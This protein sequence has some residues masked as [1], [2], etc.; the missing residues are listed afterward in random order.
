MNR[1]PLNGRRL[2]GAIAALTLLAT[3]A[4]GCEDRDE[5]WDARVDR[6]PSAWGLNNAVAIVDAHAERVLLLPVQGDLEFAPSS[7]P[8]GTGFTAAAVTPD[9]S[10]MLVL[11]RGDVPR[12]TA[13]D[14]PP[15][16][17][18]LAGW[19][20]PG[21]WAT[22]ELSDPLSAL[23]LDPQSEYAVIS[24]SADDV[25]F[26]L[27]PNE[28][29]IV[30]LSQGPTAT[31]PFPLTIRSFGGRP[32]GFTFTPTLNVPGGARRLLVVQTDRDVAL[33]DFSNLDAPEITVPLTGGNELLV[34]G[35]VAVSDGSAESD[36][37]SRVAIRVQNDPSVII[38]DLLSV[39]PE[40]AST[41]PQTFRAMPNK[42]HVGGVP[43]DISFVQTDG[44]LRLAALVPSLGQ[45]TLVD[46]L[47]GITSE[48][49][50]GA[51]FEHLS[52]VTSIVGQTDQGSD[53]A[54][55]WSSSSK[56]I[57]FWA[58]GSTVGQ[59]YKSVDRL[60]LAHTVAQVQDVPAPNNHLKVLLAPGETQFTVLDLV[61]RTA[62]PMTSSQVGTQVT[63]APDGGRAWI[64]AGTDSL[65]QLNLLSLHP[66]NV[67]LSLPVTGVFDV[68]RLDGGRAVVAVH[69]WGGI[70]ATVLD[71]YDPSLTTANQYIGLLLGELP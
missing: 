53:V 27:N 64:W 35:G 45:L 1:Y 65:A 42:V 32:Q 60:Q 19:G 59:P 21:L 18:V 36:E 68:A 34:P 16:L 40:Q 23:A 48:V 22:Y 66:R 62:S 20:Q 55:L 10:R 52:L 24:P 30:D 43:S 41:T 25:T 14:E 2:V 47:T 5:A 9:H 67:I 17:H 13:D 63:I 50:L 15:R 28:L 12:Q 11:T 51:A 7:V 37:D 70:G 44:G 33:I 61:E 57:A 39:P 38:V 4:N 46:P 49:A 69:S 71:A 29:V 31:N 54:L 8:I 56:E 3:A 58:L 26:V 6:P